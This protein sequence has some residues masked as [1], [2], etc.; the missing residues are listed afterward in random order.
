MIYVARH[1]ETTWNAAGRYQGRLESELSSLGLAQAAALAQ[2]FGARLEA[3]DTVPARI[4]SS[5]LARCLATAE[6]VADKL[7]VPIDLDERLT[8]IAHGTW[9]GRYRPEIQANDEHRFWMW[10]NDPAHVTF[11]DGE[12]LVQVMARWREFSALLEAEE[13][14]VLVVTHDVVCRCALLYAMGRSLEDLWKVRVENGAFSRIELRTDGERVIEECHTEHLAG[15]R[16]SLE[17]Q[18][19]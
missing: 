7:H 5:P 12:S 18:A 4:I 11:E 3:G 10:K 9:E 6:P 16:A 14:D 2:Y 17:D 1:G 19:L 15:I 8:E 13:H